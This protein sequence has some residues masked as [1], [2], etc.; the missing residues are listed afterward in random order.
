LRIATVVA[1][2]LF[3]TAGVAVGT[4]LVASEWTDAGGALHAC[5]QKE[6]GTV[7]LIDA[8][9]PATSPLQ[10]CNA[11]AEAEIVWNQVGPP[12]PQGP[13]GSQG[14]QGDVGP[15]GPPGPPGAD[16]RTYSGRD[17]A[18]SARVCPSRTFQSGVNVIGDPICLGIS[19]ASYGGP[20]TTLCAK[21][22]PTCSN[23]GSSEAACP[24]W[25]VLTGGGFDVDG[26]AGSVDVIESTAHFDAWRVTAVN[27]DGFNGGSVRAFAT[28]LFLPKATGGRPRPPETVPGSAEVLPRPA[29]AAGVDCV[30]EVPPPCP[31]IPRFLDLP[32]G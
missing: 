10:H 3:A 1:G 27:D 17:F 18:L 19:A 23:T 24:D 5:V 14:P 29:G 6:R 21:F 12:G 9:L 7:R 28:C 2:A 32:L 25:A 20:R 15:A 13:P 8:S 4:T 11:Q 26:V 22:D 30:R 16:G 31:G